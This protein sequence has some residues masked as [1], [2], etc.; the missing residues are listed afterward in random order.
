MLDKNEQTVIDDIQEYGWH[1]VI[2]E[3]DDEGPGF[4]YTVGLQSE[5]NH[6][7]MIVFGLPSK[8]SHDILWTIY[9][10][11][12]GGVDFRSTCVSE[13]ILEGH[14]CEFRSVDGSQLPL[15]LGYA[16]WHRRYLGDAGSLQAIQCFWPDHA[17]YFLWD[18]NVS[19]S[20]EKSQPRL[21]L[22]A[23]SKA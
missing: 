19:A 20:V 11:I 8:I 9:R 1:G 15:Y 17:G 14:K 13:N 7:E 2:I 5:L 12:K 23:A 4:E 22:P 18:S 16:Q 21:D 6:P 10:E 3:A